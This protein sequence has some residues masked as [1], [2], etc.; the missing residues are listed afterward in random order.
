MAKKILQVR[1]RSQK[2][3]T[4]LNELNAKPT[5]CLVTRHF[6]WGKTVQYMTKRGRQGSSKS[7]NQ[8]LRAYFINRTMWLSRI[9]GG[10]GLAQRWERSPPT[11]LFRVRFPDPASY[12]GWVCCWFSTLLRDQPTNIS[13]S[14][15]I[16]EC[17]A[18]S[19]RVLWAPLCS[20]G[21]QIYNLQITNYNY[22]LQLTRYAYFFGIVFFVAFS[23]YVLYDA[24]CVVVFD[25]CVAVFVFLL[26]SFL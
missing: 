21:K 16:L 3:R 18:T 13:N 6:S 25:V 15:S 19:E 14:N 17:T 24:V 4:N 12:M 11:N 26:F 20:V 10:A 7:P 23:V 9:H 8:S 2:M 5:N 22:N 1:T